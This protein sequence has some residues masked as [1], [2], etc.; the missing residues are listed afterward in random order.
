MKFLFCYFPTEFFVFLFIISYEAY[1][2]ETTRQ[3]AGYEI[4]Y[5]DTNFIWASSELQRYIPGN[6]WSFLGRTVLLTEKGMTKKDIL[7]CTLFEIE[8]LTLGAATIPCCHC[9]F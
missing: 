7:Q 9:H 4:A 5:K 8:L 6:I 1:I 2:L 3:Q